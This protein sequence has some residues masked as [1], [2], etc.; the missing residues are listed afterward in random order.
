MTYKLAYSSRSGGFVLP[1]V[2]LVIAILSLSL[3]LIA[4]RIQ[5]TSKVI[6]EIEAQFSGN[7]ALN[8]AEADTIYALLTS[9]PAKNGYE[10]NPE[11]EIDLF[12]SEKERDIPPDIWPAKGDLRQSI[13]SEGTVIVKLRDGSGFV[14]VNNI[15]EEAILALT[16]S[17]GVSKKVQK[18]LTAK[19]LDYIDEDSHRQFLGGER[20]DYRLRQ[21]S[22][23]TNASLRR[24][25][26]LS[27]IMEWN[28]ILD[29]IGYKAVL[30][31]VTLNPKVKTVKKN[32]I[33]PSFEKQLEIEFSKSGDVYDILRLDNYPTDV[34]RL[35]LYH[36]NVEGKIMRRKTEVD[37]TIALFKKPFAR[38]LLYQDTLE[39]L[40]P[41][42]D[43]NRLF[44]NL[45]G[46]K[47]VI[48]AETYRYK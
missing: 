12:G 22:P 29:E 37:K 6:A 4:Q 42:S 36:R 39:K 41:E 21:M 28:G 18:S 45:D 8:S 40:E 14:P 3:T 26:E 27:N 10:L 48:Y 44:L 7:I 24:L 16:R 43:L 35:T 34:I 30:D 32:F 13:T 46:G 2:L 1:Y 5:S 38:Q 17:F 11:K 33:E 9:V 15:D 23:P 19:L 20:A 25:G 47:H 31:R